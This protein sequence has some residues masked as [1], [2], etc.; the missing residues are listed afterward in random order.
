MRE[1]ASGY[2]IVD[3][4]HV[5]VVAAMGIAHHVQR[6]SII[7]LALYFSPSIDVIILKYWMFRYVAGSF[8]ATTINVLHHVTGTFILILP[9]DFHFLEVLIYVN[10]CLSYFT[11]ELLYP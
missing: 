3:V 2:E 9:Y 8:D 4:M 10:C 11:L 7:I 1:N 5:G 6:S